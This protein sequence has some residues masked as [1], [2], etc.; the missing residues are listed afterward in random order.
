MIEDNY[1]S[2]WEHGTL[3]ARINSWSTEF[4]VFKNSKRSYLKIKH[5]YFSFWRTDVKQST[6][7]KNEK[8]LLIKLYWKHV[9]ILEFP[10]MIFDYVYTHLS[11]LKFK[12]SKNKKKKFVSFKI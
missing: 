5:K 3:R 11:Y 9:V 7:E 12:C 8:Y 6:W 10:T 2:K 4:S 1:S